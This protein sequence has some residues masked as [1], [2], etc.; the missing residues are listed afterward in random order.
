M[1]FMN[2]AQLRDKLFLLVDLQGPSYKD[3]VFDCAGQ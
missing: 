1:A 2:A 3:V